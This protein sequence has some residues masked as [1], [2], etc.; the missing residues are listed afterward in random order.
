MA[1]E[2]SQKG[3]SPSGLRTRFSP[4]CHSRSCCSA[5]PTFFPRSG[6]FFGR[7]GMGVGCEATH[8][9]QRMGIQWR[10]LVFGFIP[11]RRLTKGLQPSH[12]RLPTFYSLPS[13]SK[14]PSHPTSPNQK[15]CPPLFSLFLD[16]ISVLIIYNVW[17]GVGCFYSFFV[18]PPNNFKFQTSFFYFFVRNFI[19]Y[20][21]IM[22]NFAIAFC[23]NE[24]ARRVIN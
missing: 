7:R 1:T 5:K 3:N 4:V 19:D 15:A 11:I 10:K 17:G 20:W 8:R 22:C 18:I 16:K 2:N 6:F 23:G 24:S 14:S 12:P 13:H 9:E 21:E